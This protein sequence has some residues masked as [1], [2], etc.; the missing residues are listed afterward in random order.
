MLSRLSRVRSRYS[1]ALFESS[2]IG[3]S[4]AFAP[5]DAPYVATAS[6]FGAA[7]LTP[8]M[9]QQPGCLRFWKSLT[10]Q[11]NPVEVA[12]RGQRSIL[13]LGVLERQGS[14]LSEWE[15]LFLRQKTTDD[16]R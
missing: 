7:T 6:S 14:L 11:G 3:V 15:Y 9:R 2:S 16:K 8:L 12:S 13:G 5:A 1:E 4:L 10:P